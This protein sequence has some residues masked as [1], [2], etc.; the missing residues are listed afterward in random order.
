MIGN[1]TDGVIL[2]IDT[3]NSMRQSRLGLRYLTKRAT[4]SRKLFSSGQKNEG[5]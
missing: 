4:L 1:M 5:Q 2:L 3:R